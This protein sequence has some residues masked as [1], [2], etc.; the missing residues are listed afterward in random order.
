ME[1]I[2]ARDQL[3]PQ[4]RLF[5]AKTPETYFGKSHI[6]CYHF[7]QQCEDYFKI[8][9]ATGINRTS[10]VATFFHGSISLR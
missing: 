7:Y 5:K 6:D 4:E 3:E 8:S 1:T 10:F 9:G 2:Q